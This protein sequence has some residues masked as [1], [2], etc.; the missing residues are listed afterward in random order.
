[1]KYCITIL[2]VLSSFTSFAKYQ[3][4]DFSGGGNIG[5]TQCYNTHAGEHRA[6]AGMYTA[7]ELTVTRFLTKKIGIGTGLMLNKYHY[8]TDLDT[9]SYASLV[10]KHDH[11]YMSIPLFATAHLVATRGDKRASHW[12]RLGIVYSHLLS[13]SYRYRRDRTDNFGYSPKMDDKSDYKTSVWL[14]SFGLGYNI[15]I[16]AKWHISVGLE[17]SLAFTPIQND[18][19]PIVPTRTGGMNALGIRAALHYTR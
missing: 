17:G 11:L 2:I 6:A 19:H 18:P 9:A 15:R 10:Y 14:G 12:F 5:L 8:E 1:M 3:A 7:G 4:W 13:S 16:S